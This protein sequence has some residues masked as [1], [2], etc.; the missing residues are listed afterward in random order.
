MADNSVEG[1]K[2]RYGDR[3]R[4][5]AVATVMIGY[6]TQRHRSQ[7]GVA[8]YHGGVRHSPGP[9]SLAGNGLYRRHDH[10]HAGLLLAAGSLRGSQDPCRSHVSLYPDFPC[11]GFCRDAGAAYRRP[12]RPGCHGRPDAAHGHVSGV[13][14]FPPRSPRPGHGYLRYGGDSGP[15]P[16]SGAGRLSG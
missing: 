4:W 14:D 8:R 15:G 2:A 13:P 3:W 11:R 12:D 5:L 6:R 9:G 16:R 7:R 10:H 1:L